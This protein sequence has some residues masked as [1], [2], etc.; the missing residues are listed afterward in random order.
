MLL[1][2][3]LCTPVIIW[4]TA[5]IKMHHKELP[6][7]GNGGYL[8]L[9]VPM[10]HHGSDEVFVLRVLDP[11]MEA[12]GKSVLDPAVTSSSLFRSHWDTNQAQDHT[13]RTYHHQS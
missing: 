8:H 12:S 10:I 1:K 11:F 7:R 9:M 13:D 4:V 5:I 6:A 3:Y 2:K